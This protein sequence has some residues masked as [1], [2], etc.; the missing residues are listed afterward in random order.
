[1]LLVALLGITYAAETNLQILSDKTF[2]S[3]VVGHPFNEV[4]F[5]MFTSGDTNETRAA[6]DVFR[7]ASEVSSGMVKFAML[8]VR[9]AP[10][11][12]AQYEIQSY[13][14]YRIFHAEGVSQLSGKPTVKK[15]LKSCLMF[16]QDLS[17][18]VTTEWKDEFTGKPSAILFTDKEK[19]PLWSGISSFFAKKDVRIGT[20]RDPEVIKAFG[21]EKLPTIV[22][23]NGTASEIYTG[24]FKFRFVK[25]AVEEFF[26]KRFEREEVTT[27]DQEMLMPDQFVSQCVGGKHICVLA[28]TKSPPDGMSILVKSSPGRRRI[29]CFAGVVG[30]PY[31]FM[32]AGGVWIYNPRKDGF[33]HVTEST[34]LLQIMD[35]VI[36][37]SAKWTK[38]AEFEAGTSSQESNTEL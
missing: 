35:R 21:I 22:F 13:P 36:D 31:K 30:L 2:Y 5:V 19:T 15:L 3:H 20:C 26:K 8:D 11:V 14:A 25:A 10:Q 12:A 32:E 28:A 29:K 38:R 17:E 1:M 9:R 16:V 7:N 6:L 34:Q 23:Y 33:I 4:W 27:D 24:V 37:G 18:N